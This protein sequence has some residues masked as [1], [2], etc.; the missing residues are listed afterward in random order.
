MLAFVAVLGLAV[1][2]AADARWPGSW[3]V[4]GGRCVVLLLA[5]VVLAGWWMGWLA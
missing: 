1:V 2:W 4:T 5:L 3:W